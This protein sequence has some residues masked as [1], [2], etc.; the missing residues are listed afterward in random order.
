MSDLED[1]Y[2]FSDSYLESESEEQSEKTEESN[3]VTNEVTKQYKLKNIWTVYD[4]TKS[5]SDNYESNTRIIG[6]IESVIE[7]WQFFNHYPSPS[8]IFNNGVC[9]PT[10]GNRAISAVSFFKKGIEPKWE[11]PVNQN[12]AEWQKI[13]FNRQNPL[14][15]LDSNWFELL[16]ACVGEQ[17][18]DTITGI[19]IV[20]SSSRKKDDQIA[21]G[22]LEYRLMYRIEL[23]FSQS[24]KCDE[25]E[26]IF[27]NILNLDSKHLLRYR[28]HKPRI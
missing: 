24:D 2:D 14:T 19:R 28:E 18:D 23:W 13:K 26:G 5:D 8:S 22:S 20:D 16:M 3:E 10:M 27:K 4:H 21:K 15:E 17:I 25:L 6:E 11:D 1:N 7:F 9:K 12:G